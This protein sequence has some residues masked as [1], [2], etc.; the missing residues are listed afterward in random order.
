[1]IYTKLFGLIVIVTLSA[2]TLDWKK[3]MPSYSYSGMVIMK[4]T[5]QAVANVQIKLSRDGI[6][7]P[8]YFVIM[9]GLETIALTSTDKNGNF[10][11]KTKSGY[12]TYAVA[13]IEGYRH[14]YK[15]RLSRKLGKKIIFKLQPHI[16]P[17]NFTNT[18]SPSQNFSRYSTRIFYK[19]RQG[20]IKIINYHDKLNSKSFLSINEYYKKKVIDE[21]T[22][23][24]FASYKNLL[25]GKGVNRKHPRYLEVTNNRRINFHWK[26]HTFGYDDLKTPIYFYQ[27]KN[28]KKIIN[29]DILY[30]RAVNPA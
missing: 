10:T 28:E 5:G 8:F 22:Y 1:M 6:R 2:C 17:Y 30:I 20:L 13:S 15:V 24:I 16:L 4:S 9:S 18:R 12:C 23:L 27:H 26:L 11:A 19:I 21:D 14:R 25:T 3:D 7:P 29:S